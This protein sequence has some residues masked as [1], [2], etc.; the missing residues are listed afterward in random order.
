MNE[1]P[2]TDIE[3]P[4]EVGYRHMEREGILL[5]SADAKPTLSQ[6]FMAQEES[7]DWERQYRLENNLLTPTTIRGKG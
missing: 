2:M 6:E 7:E 5:D 3:I 1:P 4:R